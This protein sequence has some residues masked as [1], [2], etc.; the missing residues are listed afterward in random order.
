MKQPQDEFRRKI[1]PVCGKPFECYTD[2]WCY[3][4]TPFGKSKKYLCSWKCLNE[5][6]SIRLKQRKP[7]GRKPKGGMSD[8]KRRYDETD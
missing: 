5:F 8:A 3:H 2:T 6:D 7:S 4:R 1:C